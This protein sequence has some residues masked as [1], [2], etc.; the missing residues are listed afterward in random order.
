M[1]FLDPKPLTP[2]AA[3]SQINTP[4]SAIATALNATYATAAALAAK[5]DTSALTAKLDASTAATTYAAKSVETSKLDVT[6]A[7]A[8]YATNASVTTELDARVVPAVA[9]AI[10]NDPTVAAEAAALAQEDAGLVRGTDTRLPQ[11]VG[12]IPGYKEVVVT[13]DGFVISGVQDDGTIY[14]FFD[15]ANP[16]R[17]ADPVSVPGYRNIVF[18]KTKT[19][20]LEAD[21]TD[22]SKYF[23][24]LTAAVLDIPETAIT[25]TAAVASFGDSMTGDH[26]GTGTS[27][28]AAIG[29]ALGL[30][31]F[32]GGVPGQTTTE[33]AFRSGGLEMWGTITGGTIPTSGTVGVTITV[34][35]TATWATSSA[36]TFAVTARCEDGTEIPGSLVKAIGNTWTFQPTFLAVAKA[37]PR[38]VKFISDQGTAYSSRGIIFRAGRNNPDTDVATIVRD[39]KAVREWVYATQARPRFLALPLYNPSDAPVGSAIYNSYKAI[40]EAI[41][42]ECG[43]DYYDLRRWLIKN[44]L[45]AAGITPTSQDTT[46]IAADIVPISLRY[47]GGA[48]TTHLTVAARTVEGVQ[49]ANVIKSKGWFN[50]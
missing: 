8:T 25:R 22:G 20:V 23:H 31:A 17:T 16:A 32:Q 37:A 38:E 24:K 39:Y 4:G 18:D 2:G 30:P 3:V 49:I 28:G 43:P 12:T 40:N 6:A 48:D 42:K 35:V 47:N 50:S 21:K 5:A 27:T 13:T 44:G 26:G 33:A 46:D 41:E 34:P 14:N 29:T 7:A 15:T 1:S 11:N 36:W 45:S 10:A 9:D 19:Y